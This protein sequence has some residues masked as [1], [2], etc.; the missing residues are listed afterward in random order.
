MSDPV[1]TRLVIV[2]NANG[3]HMRPADLLVKTA[4]RYQSE[5]QIE[6]EGQAVDCKSI[7]GLLTL[8]ATQGCELTIRVQGTDADE[9]LTKIVELFDQGF[10][11]ADEEMAPAG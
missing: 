6:R 8:G 2:R 5:I 4:N 1:L 10:F 9:A 11:E 7:L 3:L